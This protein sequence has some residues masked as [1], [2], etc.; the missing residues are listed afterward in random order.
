MEK[1]YLVEDEELIPIQEQDKATEEDL[2]FKVSVF[3]D[4]KEMLAW[5]ITP[6]TFKLLEAENKN[7][8]HLLNKISDLREKISPN[9]QGEWNRKEQEEN[10]IEEEQNDEEA[11]GESEVQEK[12]NNIVLI[13]SDVSNKQTSEKV[14]EEITIA[15][16]EEIKVVPVKKRRKAKGEKSDSEI[17]R[18]QRKGEL[19][20][21]TLREIWQY[22]ADSLAA[23]YSFG[24]K[25]CGKNFDY[26]QNL[27]MYVD[28]D[29][30]RR[31]FIKESVQKESRITIDKGN[32][33]GKLSKYSKQSGIPLNEIINIFNSV[34]W[35]CMDMETFLRI[36]DENLLWT[37]QEDHDLLSNDHIGF[38]IFNED[39]RTN[40]R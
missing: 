36:R 12:R 2:I 8:L 3:K 31:H 1:I 9:K 33:W 18:T 24:L 34:S 4:S 38:E 20:L 17:K 37:S 27:T 39:E 28:P 26:D 21:K 13:D 7:S 22:D 11:K 25:K 35:D 30:Q 15:E 29:M 10:R 5:D 14:R 32:K 40:S 6:D 23:S 16:Q 19:E